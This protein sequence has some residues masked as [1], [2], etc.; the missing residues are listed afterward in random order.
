MTDP[1]VEADTDVADRLDQPGFVDTSEGLRLVQGIGHRVNLSA[2]E[3]TP[4]PAIVGR[5]VV[6][7]RA[8]RD[9]ER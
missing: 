1:T 9:P 6:I 5:V 8:G 3:G 7:R 2:P 4:D